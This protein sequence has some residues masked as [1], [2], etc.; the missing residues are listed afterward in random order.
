M[1]HSYILLIRVMNRN[2]KQNV[3]FLVVQF[4]NLMHYHLFKGK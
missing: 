2:F 3:N 1:Q 4:N